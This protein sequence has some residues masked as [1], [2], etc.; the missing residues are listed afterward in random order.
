LLPAR[1]LTA[2]VLLA[3]FLA[4]LFWLERWQFA[5]LAGLVVA[6]AASEWAALCGL[7]R[8][9]AAAFAAGVVA[10]YGLLAAALLGAPTSGWTF[11]LATVF[12]LAIAPFW[13]YRGLTAAHRPWLVPAGLVAIVPA[14]VAMVALQ[15]RVLL[16][17]L[18]LTWVA[19]TAA[20]F[21]GRAWGRRKLA[22][23]ISPGK[24]V[25]GALGALVA[26]V[27]YAII[28]AHLLPE[29]QPL[30]S[31]AAWIA[32]I[33]A[34]LLLTVLSILGDLFESALKRQAGAKDSGTLLPGHGGVLDRIDSATSTL[35]VAA[36]MF[37]FLQHP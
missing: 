13:L 8:L 14:G 28:C 9:P 21:T 19:D 2:A 26:A 11:M 7:A 25:E 35:P 6:I 4:A 1:I 30:A 22:P 31:G 23:S 18:A 10:C 3:V 36:L 17:V 32:L 15:P 37:Q 27:I 33:V 29:L 12:W 20:Y 16:V 24:T 34:T 5:V